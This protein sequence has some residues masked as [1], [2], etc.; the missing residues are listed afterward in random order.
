MLIRPDG[1]IAGTIGGGLV[2]ATARA[3]G[4]EVLET[5]CPHLLEFEMKAGSAAEEGM[6]CGGEV[7]IWIDY[8]NGGDMACREVYQALEDVI[9]RAKG[10]HG[11]YLPEPGQNPARAWPAANA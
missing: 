8:V 3:A 9:H 1:T 5:A 2:E 11:F 10:W 6:A 4:A 7:E